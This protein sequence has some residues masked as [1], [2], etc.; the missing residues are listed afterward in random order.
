MFWPSTQKCWVAAV[1][2]SSN[3]DV[4]P[5]T[6]S[7][8]CSYLTSCF[9]CN[10]FVLV[11]LYL[12][13]GYNS[14]YLF[15]LFL[16]VNC[17]WGCFL[18]LWRMKEF[19]KL[20]LHRVATDPWNPWNTPEIPLKYPWNTPEKHW[21]MKMPLKYPEIPWKITVCQ[22]SHVAWKYHSM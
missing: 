10:L 18:I 20:F 3:L 15:V 19:L 8:W 21:P 17:T 16:S 4:L 2:V 22:L 5:F 12:S 1:I 9:H 11:P 13:V 7:M 14:I 6:C